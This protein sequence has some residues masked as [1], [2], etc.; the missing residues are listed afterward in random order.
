[1]TKRRCYCCTR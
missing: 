1:M